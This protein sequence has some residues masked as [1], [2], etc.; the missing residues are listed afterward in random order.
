MED[1]TAGRHQHPLKTDA[2]WE[3]VR[4]RAEAIQAEGDPAAWYQ[5]VAELL[6]IIACGEEGKLSG[7]PALRLMHLVGVVEAGPR[8]RGAGQPPKRLRAEEDAGLIRA[9]GITE[10]AKATTLL[11]GIEAAVLIAQKQREGASLSQSERRK[12]AKSAND[13]A[14][15]A[16]EEGGRPLAKSEKMV[17]RVRAAPDRKMPKN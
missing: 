3:C 9:A 11:G 8:K 2:G 6:T 17:R 4:R 12:V 16:A 1:D 13:R 7:T 14:N 10:N 15:K 5:R